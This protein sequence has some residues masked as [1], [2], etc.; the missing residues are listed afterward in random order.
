MRL[1]VGSP[2]RHHAV[3]RWLAPASVLVALV[4]VIAVVATAGGAPRAGVAA[5]AASSA[6]AAP[7][8]T[9]SYVVRSGDTLSHIALRHGVSVDDILR[10][11]PKLDPQT[12]P[13]G[14]RLTLTR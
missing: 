4:A 1:A 11:N 5:V 10:L 6:P 7:A 3:G 14:Q 13:V 8:K 12:V 9:T 2:P